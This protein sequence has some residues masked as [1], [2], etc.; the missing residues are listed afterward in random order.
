[1]EHDRYD[2]ARQ[3][4]ECVKVELLQRNHLKG[5]GP[6]MQFFS[7][8]LAAIDKLQAGLLRREEPTQEEKELV[9]WLAAQLEWTRQCTVYGDSILYSVA[10]VAAVS[11]LMGG[12]RSSWM[13]PTCW[14]IYEHTC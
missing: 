3:E 8:E 14:D 10:T 11:K 13:A 12:C 4:L 5:Y 7:N 2:W 1:M 6:S 9:Y